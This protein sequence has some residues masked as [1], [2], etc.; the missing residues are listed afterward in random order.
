MLRLF[1]L[2]LLL[3]NAGYFAWS[4]GH[5][6]TLGWGPVEQREP[7]RLAQQLAPDQLRL[8]GGPPPATN[9]TAS[10]AP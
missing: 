2:V 10:T 6:R 9:G 4:Q 5:L 1:A 3:A 8:E 7:E